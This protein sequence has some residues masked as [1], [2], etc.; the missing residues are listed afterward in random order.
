MGTTMPAASAPRYSARP[1]RV[2]IR[3]AAQLG[4]TP[5][6][7]QQ[8]LQHLPERL[9]VL[10]RC[11][12]AEGKPE[13]A[14]R[15]FKPIEAAFADTPRVAL[16]E[17]VRKHHEADT[18]EELLQH[19]FMVD[20][21]PANRRAWIAQLDVCAAMDRQLRLALLAADA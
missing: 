1:G 15:L 10:I 3:A 7:A 14:E 19:R 8:A 21:S 9:S 5:G 12:L 17:A 13:V 4:L 20:P 18:A 2:A 11:A 6:S 16:A